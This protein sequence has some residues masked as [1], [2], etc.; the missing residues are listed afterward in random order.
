MFVIHVGLHYTGSTSI[1]SALHISKGNLVAKKIFVPWN[2]VTSGDATWLPSAVPHIQRLVD[3]GWT[4]ITSGEG[5]LGSSRSVYED[6][7]RVARTICE[8]YG[9]IEFQIIVYLRPQHQWV[10]SAYARHVIEGG[11]EAPG[12][13]VESVLDREF[14]R[15]SGLITVLGEEVGA[16]RLVVRPFSTSRDVVQDFWESCQLGDMPEYLRGTRANQGSPASRLAALRAIG[17]H[18]ELAEPN[19]MAGIPLPASNGDRSSSLLPVESQEKL[20]ELFKEDWPRVGQLAAQHVSEA[21]ADFEEV[22]QEELAWR[23]A[24][25]VGDELG[26]LPIAQEVA[27]TMMSMVQ[28][29]ARERRGIHGLRGDL[30]FFATHG[31]R[32]RTYQRAMKR[33]GL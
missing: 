30:Q 20:W 16:E 24:L 32:H 17:A 27:S 11:L 7:A 26:V 5:F 22:G 14:L 29:G 25:F 19:P 21:R 1:Q 12:A 18:A 9:S 8:L 15:W 10:S 2:V 4:V 13:F 23:P 33:A 6:A 28:N 31:R 3:Q